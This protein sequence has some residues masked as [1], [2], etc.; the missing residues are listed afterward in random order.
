MSPLI[1]RFQ[2][3]KADKDNTTYLRALEGLAIIANLSMLRNM[4]KGNY[5]WH[6][7]RHW[8]DLP[9]SYFFFRKLI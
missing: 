5:L 9:N 6:R 8:N 3:Y 7:D 2:I 4:Y 1:L